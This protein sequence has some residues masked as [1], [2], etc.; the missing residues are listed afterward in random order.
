MNSIGTTPIAS[1]I[2]EVLQGE[3]PKLK[4][5]RLFSTGQY[6][7]A[8]F[9]ISLPLPQGRMGIAIVELNDA[10]CALNPA[11]QPHD[12]LTQLQ[13]MKKKSE[14]KA[15]EWEIKQ[16]DLYKQWEHNMAY[17]KQVLNAYT[18]PVNQVD[19]SNQSNT[20]EQSG[21]RLLTENGGQ[22]YYGGARISNFTVS[23]IRIAGETRYLLRS[24]T[25]PG[26]YVSLDG[27]AVSSTLSFRS[28]VAGLGDFHWSGNQDALDQLMFHLRD[29]QVAPLNPSDSLDQSAQSTPDAQ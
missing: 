29:A 20:P 16:I 28:Y 4:I 17:A 23:K 6:E 11:L 10:L 15:E 18:E 25:K 21:E 5:T 22:Y 27:D 1:Q 26:V 7:H 8:K 19:P 2:G 14:G 9:E 24:Q 3:I 13:Y 12:P